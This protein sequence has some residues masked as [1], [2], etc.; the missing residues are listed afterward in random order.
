MAD[1]SAVLADIAGRAQLGVKTSL[2]EAFVIS[3]LQANELIDQDARSTEILKPYGR[4]R[5]TSKWLTTFNGQ[6]LV[7]T[8]ECISIECYPAVMQYLAQFERPLRARYEVRRGDYDWWVIRQVSRTDIFDNPKVVYPDLCSKSTFA[9][10]VDGMYP[11][12][13]V[14]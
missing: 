13:T 1:S 3:A 5:D 8:R 11:N 12:N 4:G 9:L 6:Y 10:N 7:C 2:N 14:F